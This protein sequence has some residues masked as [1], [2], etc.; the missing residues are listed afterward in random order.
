MNQIIEIIR[1]PATWIYNLF[2]TA[3][4][5]QMFAGILAMVMCF[6]Y[7]IYPLVGGQNITL[8][9]AALNASDRASAQAVAKHKADMAEARRIERQMARQQRR[10]KK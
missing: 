2:Q 8:G 3:G 10:S 9:D 4:V 7:I 1:A 6:R 5:W